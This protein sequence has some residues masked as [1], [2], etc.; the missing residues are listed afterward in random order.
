MKHK[1]LSI[2]VINTYRNM[3]FKYNV[4][5]IL[6]IFLSVMFNQNSHSV[7]KLIF[8]ISGGTVNQGINFVSLLVNLLIVMCLHSLISYFLDVYLSEQI[9][10]VIIRVREKRKYFFSIIRTIF[11]VTMVYFFVVFLSYIFMIK[12]FGYGF[13]VDELD[14]AYGIQPVYVTIIKLIIFQFF[15]FI[16]M[17]CIQFLLRI[18][19]KLERDVLVFFIFYVIL[20]ILP[21][22]VPLGGNLGRHS[23]TILIN[24]TSNEMFITTIVISLGIILLTY[25]IIR[26]KEYEIC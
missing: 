25:I 2:N 22:S 20:S 4:L 6:V 9:Y 26:R 18:N 19:F 3:L 5:L 10:T 12:I 17:V 11:I 14:I 15:S 23:E 8:Q 13:D 21:F 7:I 1:W 16:S 24:N